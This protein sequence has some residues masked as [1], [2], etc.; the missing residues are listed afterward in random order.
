MGDGH[1]GILR[2]TELQHV[3]SSLKMN[4]KFKLQSQLNTLYLRYKLYRMNKNTFEN[5]YL[6][7]NVIIKEG[8]DIKI[9]RL[10]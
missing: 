5:D 10:I 1:R 8:N 4:F 6:I 9:Q 7:P 2:K 3:L